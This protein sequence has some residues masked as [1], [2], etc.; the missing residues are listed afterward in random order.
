MSEL[1]FP[2]PL[3]GFV[4]L[5]RH[6]N[7]SMFPEEPAEVSRTAGGQVLR[8]SIGPGLWRGRMAAVPAYNEDAS[9][10]EALLAL[11]SRPGASFLVTDTRYRGPRMDPGG[12]VLNEPARNGLPNSL[13]NGAALGVIGSGG[14]LPTGWAM[15]GLGSATAEVVSITPEDDRPTIRIRFT[16]TPSANIFLALCTD[17]C[18]PAAAGQQWTLSYWAQVVGGDLT[19]VGALNIRMVSFNSGGT[20]LANSL[21]DFAPTAATLLRRTR[22]W[23]IPA[24]SVA[25]VQSQVLV[26]SITG[27]VDFTLKLQAPQI[28]LGAVAAA[29][30][31]TPRTPQLHS[32]DPGNRLLT[33]RS[34]PPGYVLSPGDMLGWTYGSSPVRYALHRLVTGA[35][36]EGNGTCGPLEVTPRLRGGAVGG[37][38]EMVRPVCKAVPLEVQPGTGDGLITSGATLSWVQTVK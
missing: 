15:T 20:S 26:G 7:V 17:A 34:L 32:L 6:S 1:A 24:G 9:A 29:W 33:L 31:S 14:A 36:A 10:V 8:A 22:T 11:L 35:T 19:N 12:A 27:A 2:L 21:A 13:G 28:E 30:Q 18:T 23:T 37:A 5:M 25:T 38:V 16:G 4:D 3:S